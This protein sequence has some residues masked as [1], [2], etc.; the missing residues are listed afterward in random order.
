[1]PL[2]NLGDLSKPRVSRVP[3]FGPVDHVDRQPRSVK[4]KS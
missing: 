3:L 2:E 4:Q 1:L